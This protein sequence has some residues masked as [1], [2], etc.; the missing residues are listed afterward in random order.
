MEPRDLAQELIC[1]KEG[2]TLHAH[3][4]IGEWI[5]CPAYPAKMYHRREGIR[6]EREMNGSCVGT[7]S[8]HQEWRSV[9]SPPKH[10]T[11]L[12]RQSVRQQELKGAAFRKHFPSKRGRGSP[13]CSPRTCSVL[14]PPAVL[15]Q[16]DPWCMGR[17]T[18]EGGTR[19]Q[20]RDLGLVFPPKENMVPLQPCM[21]LGE[22]G[23]SRG[24]DQQP[25]KSI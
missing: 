3:E 12:G 9:G 11:L 18:T 25:R 6:V 22:E 20:P 8:P 14:T 24:G 13:C 5:E 7:A 19:I 4:K 16:A 15:L 2:I 10:V 21:H 23:C 17:E 1:L